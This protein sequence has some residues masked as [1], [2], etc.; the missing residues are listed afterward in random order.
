MRVLVSFFDTSFSSPVQSTTKISAAL[1]PDAIPTEGSIIPVY[2]AN[3][4]NLG[5]YVRLSSTITGKVLMR[6]LSDE[7]IQKPEEVFPVG[8]LCQARLLSISQ[9][10]NEAKLSLKDSV[11]IGDQKARKE[12]EKIKENSI[13]SGTVQRVTQDGVFVT[14]QGTSLTGLSRRAAAISDESKALSEEYEVGDVVRCKI[15]KVS[16]ISMKIALGLRAHYFK[17]S[18]QQSNDEAE[19]SEGESESADGDSDEEEEDDSAMDVSDNEAS[20]DSGEV[21]EDAFCD[22]ND[23]DDEEEGSEDEEEDSD[24]DSEN[25]IRMLEEG[26]DTDSEVERMIKG[27]ALASGSEDEDQSESDSEASDAPPAKKAPASKKAAAAAS[28]KKAADSDDSDSDGDVKVSSL[29]GRN[30]GGVFGKKAGKEAAGGLQWDDS[31]PLL[32]A[33][34]SSAR[35]VKETAQVV[36][37]ESSEEEDSVDEEGDGK[38][39]GKS[40]LRSRQKESV[41][42]KAEQDIRSREVNHND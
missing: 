4:S 28:T 37:E 14:L 6:D 18:A 30:A 8:K 42:R 13:M 27:A 15:L 32:A 35:T 24:D 38:G 25:N 39:A 36:A 21:S 5:C 41:R 7:F 9:I 17:K 3:A 29:F 1:K 31:A 22:G 11:V 12:I 10:D 26:E 40:K 2:V 20:E 33:P 23:D 16:K 34:A 19:D